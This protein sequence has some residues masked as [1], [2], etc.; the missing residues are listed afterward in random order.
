MAPGVGNFTSGTGAVSLPGHVTVS[1]NKNLHMAS[2]DG[3]FVT[4]AADGYF[5][6]DVAV[7]AD[8]NIIMNPNGN[9]KFE[10]GNGTV[11]IAGNLSLA[12]END[13]TFTSGSGA[14]ILNGSTTVDG[15]KTFGT[16]SGAVTLSGD[17]TVVTEKD[18]KM[19]TG[20]GAF[21]SGSGSVTLNGPTAVTGTKV[22]TVGAA[23]SAGASMFHGNLQAG[24]GGRTDHG[25]TTE[26][27]GNV[28]FAQGCPVGGCTG[29]A[30]LEAPTTIEEGNTFTIGTHVNITC[31]GTIASTSNVCVA[32]G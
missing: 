25:V 27:Y 26:I 30:K 12:M 23:G 13:R 28:T 21:Q 18:L 2:G 29:A 17:V 6:G 10:S 20:T 1:A 19:A 31:H 4:G 9:G 3:S 15:D 32:N 7:A 22:F 5:N 14:V 24:S 16:G 11:T 8:K